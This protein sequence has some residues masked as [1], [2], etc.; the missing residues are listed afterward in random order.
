VP[1]V[2]LLRWVVRLAAGLFFWRLVT[3]RRNA[4]APGAPPVRGRAAARRIN[5]RAAA[6]A[7]REGVSLGW[8]AIT[9]VT[10]LVLASL[11][12]DAGVS[13]VVLSPRWL[14]ATLLG[15]A[16]VALVALYLESLWLYRAVAARRRRRHDELLRREV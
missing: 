11:L 3:A 8:R 13:L 4:Y 14:G 15:L 2:L 9:V 1:W 6:L 5:P 10:L 16:V 7:I 12:V